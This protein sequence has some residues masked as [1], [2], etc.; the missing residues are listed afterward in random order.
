MPK[1]GNIRLLL[2]LLFTILLSGCAYPLEQGASCPACVTP[3]SVTAT[4]CPSCWQGLI[5]GRSSEQDV[6][7]FIEQK[8]TDKEK[9]QAM[10]SVSVR[11]SCR[12]FRWFTRRDSGFDFEDRVREIHVE[13]GVTSYIMVE[14][15]LFGPTMKDVV[16][17]YGPPEYVLSLLAVGPDG[18]HYILEV[19]YPSRGLAFKLHPSQAN[20]GRITQRTRISAIEYYV[21]GDVKNLFVVR[22]ACF[23]SRSEDVLPGVEFE[24]SV[25]RPWTG[26][27]EIEV[28]L[29]R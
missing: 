8:L 20:T 29:D 26:F 23:H 6:M 27:G 13:H 11:R 18:Q 10:N 9:D 21:P 15:P 5:P 2:F 3:T 16:G 1:M 19:Y 12:V 28:I 25:V 17:V 24:A 4:P 14:M 22:S 7:N